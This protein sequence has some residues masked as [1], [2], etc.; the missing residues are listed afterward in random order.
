MYV[1]AAN[2]EGAVLKLISPTASVENYLPR[3]W[4]ADAS[5][6][7]RIGFN[8]LFALEP[9]VPVF[10]PLFYHNAS[11]THTKLTGQKRYCTRP[12]V[13]CEKGLADSPD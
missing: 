2:P 4:L 12:Q 9:Q 1:I 6:P 11:P 7:A 3:K 10:A 5:L 13:N 8:A